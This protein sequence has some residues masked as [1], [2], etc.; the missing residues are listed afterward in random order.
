MEPNHRLPVRIRPR[1][2]AAA[3]HGVAVF[4]S[5]DGTLL[6]PVTFDAGES[7]EAVRRLAAAGI[8]LIPLS[9]MTLDEI[10]PLAGELGLRHAMIVEA[11]GAI[12]RWNGREWELEP[13]GPPAETLLD[14]VLEVENR[15]GASLLVYSAL[16]EEDAARL[17]GRSGEMLRASTH[18]GFSEPFVIESGSLE[19][20]RRAAAAIGF[21]VRRGR[22]FL[23][24]CRACDEGEAFARLRDELRCGVAVALGG[25]PVDGE[26]LMRADVPI[27]VPGPDGAADPELLA[28]VPKARVAPAPGPAGW[29]AAIDDVLPGLSAPK[30]RAREA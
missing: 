26:F 4:T 12:A 23:H 2:R 13:C 15:S 14:V 27:I 3:A 6:D 22:R 7:R 29:T 25:T 16:A 17:S 19:A 24:L 30:T 5:I 11:G 1:T 18:R 10:A 28:M 20:V 9:V 21:S 8:P